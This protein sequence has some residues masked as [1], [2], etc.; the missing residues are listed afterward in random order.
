LIHDGEVVGPTEGRVSLARNQAQL[1]VIERGCATLPA[2]V[3]INKLLRY[4]HDNAV[5]AGTER[6]VTS[7]KPPVRGR[8]R[9]ALTAYYRHNALSRSART[10]AFADADHLLAAIGIDLPDDYLRQQQEALVEAI[11]R[12]TFAYAADQLKETGLRANTDKGRSTLNALANDSSINLGNSDT[13]LIAVALGQVSVDQITPLLPKYRGAAEGA[14][15]TTKTSPNYV[16]LATHLGIQNGQYV[17]DITLNNDQPGIAAT[18]LRLLSRHGLYMVSGSRSKLQEQ[19]AYVRLV[20]EPLPGRAI[21]MQTITEQLE[22]L[23]I[24]W[25]N[26]RPVAARFLVSVYLQ[27]NPESRNQ[28]IQQLQSAFPGVNML[29]MQMDKDG[30]LEMILAFPEDITVN[31]VDAVRHRFKRLQETATFREEELITAFEVSN[32]RVSEDT[33]AAMR[34]MAETRLE[35]LNQPKFA[36]MRRWGQ[37]LFGTTFVAQQPQNEEL[38][39]T[40]RLLDLATELHYGEFRKSW[41]KQPYMVHPLEVFMMSIDQGERDFVTLVTGLVHDVLENY[42]EHRF[43]QDYPGE[44]LPSHNDPRLKAW[45]KLAADRIADLVAEDPLEGAHAA[46]SARPMPPTFGI[47]HQVVKLTRAL[48]YN[49][50]ETVASQSLRLT[51]ARA[52]NLKLRDNTHNLRTVQEVNTVRFPR[53]R[54][55]RQIAKA[56]RFSLPRVVHLENIDPEVDL[57][58]RRAFLGELIPVVLALTPSEDLIYLE[59]GEERAIVQQEVGQKVDEFAE[60]MTANPQFWPTQTSAESREQF[61]ARLR[62][63]ARKPLDSAGALPDSGHRT[64]RFPLWIWKTLKEALSFAKTQNGLPME[65]FNAI[66]MEGRGIAHVNS[67]G[68]IVI[69]KEAVPVLTR[70]LNAT[71]GRGTA[72]SIGR[73]QTR[74]YLR[75]LEV[76]HLQLKAAPSLILDLYA[77]LDEP[78]L[79]MGSPIK[80]RD[81]LQNYF[82]NNYGEEFRKGSLFAEELLSVFASDPAYL[83]TTVKVLPDKDEPMALLELP[84][85]VSAR[86]TEYIGRLDRLT[87]TPRKHRTLVR[88]HNHIDSDLSYDGVLAGQGPF[89]HSDA[90][91]QDLL[92]GYVER[93]RAVYADIGVGFGLGLRQAKRVHGDDLVTYGVDLVDHLD[94]LTQPVARREIERIGGPDILNKRYAY[95]FVQGTMESVRLPEPADVITLFYSTDYSEDPLQAISNCYNQL[96][97]GGILIATLNP[98]GIFFLRRTDTLAAPWKLEEWVSRLQAEGVDAH[99]SPSGLLVLFR[100]DD[101]LLQLQLQAQMHS[102]DRAGKTMVAYTARSPEAAWVSFAKSE[103]GSLLFPVIVGTMLLLQ[104]AIWLPML[105]NPKIVAALSEGLMSFVGFMAVFSPWRLLRPT[106]PHSKELL[107]RAA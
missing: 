72:Q 26:T 27:P 62:A 99:L 50:H 17:L 18:L 48:T 79:Y 36:R 34:K 19:G 105:A 92:A 31:T 102:R 47:Q 81:Q 86:L 76:R 95:Q 52:D 101:R 24:P 59:P 35:E 90:P 22:K 85:G 49:R 37:Y 78:N 11:R 71:L 10:H 60:F 33:A 9:P 25:Q 13:L 5:R 28:F 6:L 39:M 38:G 54:P 93:G 100:H 65:V 91:L 46:E 80:G 23:Q 88:S 1:R 84:P 53:S 3:E 66:V 43:K 8:R 97:I 7:L 61:M 4:Q 70:V 64:A 42:P 56:I 20:L 67:D 106:E 107:H 68:Q 32:N 75:A 55:S 57:N 96:R 29:A 87:I 77:A 89:V 21:D 30:W 14:N 15:G 98:N 82:A 63:G 45:Q 103:R 12:E 51:E 69:Y 44:P 104:F 58:T 2:I 83:G 74:A 41:K 73:A 94:T 16:E 40:Q